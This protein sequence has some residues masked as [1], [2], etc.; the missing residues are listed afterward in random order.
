MEITIGK[1]K[2]DQSNV[3]SMQSDKASYNQ[4]SNIETLQDT[5]APWEHR[6]QPNK[7][8]IKLSRNNSNYKIWNYTTTSQ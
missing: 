3:G 1:S 8:L 7:L 5:L 4:N 6:Q 2:W